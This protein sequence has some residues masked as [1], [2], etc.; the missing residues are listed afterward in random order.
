MSSF[1]FTLTQGAAHVDEYRCMIPL[2]L[3]TV[4][5]Y[6]IITRSCSEHFFCLTV[7][8]V[9][10]SSLRDGLSFPMLHGGTRLGQTET[11]FRSSQGL[12]VEP[13]VERYSPVQSWPWR[14]QRWRPVVPWCRFLPYGALTPRH[15]RTAAVAGRSLG[16]DRI[17]SIIVTRL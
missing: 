7:T 12:P 1:L 11:T 10:F 9:Q 4:I 14:N 6:C 2:L 17:A 15:R 16:R 3:R 13:V 5:S 8:C